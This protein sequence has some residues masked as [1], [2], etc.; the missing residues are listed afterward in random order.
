MQKHKNGGLGQKVSIWVLLP[1]WIMVLLLALGLW[2]HLFNYSRNSGQ[3]GTVYQID[4]ESVEITSFEMFSP[5]LVFPLSANTLAAAIV[6]DYLGDTIFVTSSNEVYLLAG[7][8]QGYVDK[9]N[10]MRCGSENCVP[11][12]FESTPQ[13]MQRE[14]RIQIMGQLNTQANSI[15]IGLE[16][17]PSLEID[18]ST[19][20]VQK[21]SLEADIQ[22]LD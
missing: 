13:Y 18:Q 14:V 17:Y 21:I 9:F 10:D 11:F 20:R 19:D 12:L 2:L 4:S 1:M 16:F 7:W 3:S 5:N 8:S 22:P 6:S 15:S